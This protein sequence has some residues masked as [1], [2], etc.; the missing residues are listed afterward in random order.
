MIGDELKIEAGER[1]LVGV[2]SVGTPHDSDSACYALYDE[3][4][5]QI[6]WRRV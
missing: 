1:W 2:G 6:T 5:R 3:T 4:A